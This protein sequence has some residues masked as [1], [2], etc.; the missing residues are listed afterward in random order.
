MSDEVVSSPVN[1]HTGVLGMLAQ[2]RNEIANAQVLTLEVPRWTS[3]KLLIR[4]KPVDHAV[5]KRSASIQERAVKDNDS[6]KQAQVEIDTNADI[7]INACIEIVAVMPNGDE[8]GVG[9]DG[10]RTRFDADMAIALGMPE[11]STARA[12]CKST[13][14][15][16]GDLLLAAKMLGEWS[17]YRIGA[18]E[19]AIAGES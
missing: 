19:E 5:L 3:P 11:N 7:L 13:F 9:P 17:G 15:T 16:G 8:V 1:E 6:A 12:V 2:R 4:F 10:R 18:V 14:I